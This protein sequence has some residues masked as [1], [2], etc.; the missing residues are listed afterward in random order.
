MDGVERRD[1]L[2]GYLS[3]VN[4]SNAATRMDRS[5]FWG[6]R[7]DDLLKFLDELDA[8]TAKPE[9]DGQGNFVGLDL[10]MTCEH[11]TVGPHRA[12]CFQ[13]GEWCYPDD[14]CARCELTRRD[15]K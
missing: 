11:R 5:A 9:F 14:L 12:W 2:A 3:S 15:S 8:P 6:E 1:R 7:A 4:W 13:C 10:N